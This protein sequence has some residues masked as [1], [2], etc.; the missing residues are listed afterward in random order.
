MKNKA[1]LIHHQGYG[2]LFTNN[3]IC[4][5]YSSIYE[6]LII[7]ASDEPRRI[8]LEN[9]YKNIKNIKCIVPEFTLSF[10]NTDACLLCMT[11]GSPIAC[12]RDERNKCIYINYEHYKEYDNIKI[13]CF[14]QYKEW[15]K[16]LLKSNSFSH[17]FYEY[18]N[19]KLEDRIELFSLNEDKVLQECVYNKAIEDIKNN[20]YIVVHDDPSRNIIINLNTEISRYNLNNSSN[21]FLD[22]IKILEN[23]KE[24]HFIDSSYSV[25]IYFLS[26][27]NK[28]I[29]HI[30]KFLHGYNRFGRDL[31]IYTNPTPHNWEIIQ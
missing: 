21:I 27:K 3:A 6:E 29:K 2:D 28:K 8:V 12:P 19:I 31:Q 22:Q 1:T 16:F 14:K 7:F 5:Y 20:D 11:L 9:M 30:P 4:K 23:A 24:I 18:E 25:L 10:N 26:F 17:A 15:E 13:G